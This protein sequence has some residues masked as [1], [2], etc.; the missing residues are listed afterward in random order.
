MILM[1]QLSEQSKLTI[2]QLAYYAETASS[3]YKVYEIDKR[4]G[5]K[6]LIEHPSRPLKLLQR[7]INSNLVENLPVHR[8]ATAYRKGAGI[9]LNVTKHAKTNYTVRVDFQSFF[10]S[11][12][13]SGIRKYL[14]H[15]RDNG[16]VLSLRDIEFI[17]KIVTRNGALTIGAPTSPKLT[18]AMMHEFDASMD[19]WCREKNLIYTRYADD[20]FVSAYKQD[21]LKTVRNKIVSLCRKFPYA[22]LQINDGKT[23]HLSRKYHRSVT[24]IVIS[25]T[26]QSSLGRDKKRMIRSLVFK[27]LNQRLGVADYGKTVGLLAF[28]FDVEKTFYDSLCRKFEIPNILKAVRE[29]EP[30]IE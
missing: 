3:R 8:C 1:R 26:G 25:S 20:I 23:L 22:K 2:R 17:A 13:I 12:G 4:N 29:I 24:G 7:W 9:K 28:A 21:Q 15:L 6:R 16:A 27:H 5:G 11:F 10:P 14:K 18:N 30:K 19:V